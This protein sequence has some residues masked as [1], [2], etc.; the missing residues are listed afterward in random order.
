MAG[1]YMAVK[2][3]IQRYCDHSTYPF[4][5][6]SAHP[7]ASP[8]CSSHRMLLVCLLLVG[9]LRAYKARKAQEGPT[10]TKMLENNATFNN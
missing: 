4:D 3:Y 2:L 5:S 9:L 1:I 10:Y 7:E 8:T 6:L